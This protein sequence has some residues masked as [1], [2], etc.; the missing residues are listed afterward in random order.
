MGSRMFENLQRE[1]DRL[2]RLQ[3]V[4]V[5][6]EADTEGYVDKECPA[7]GCLFQF[8]ILA[9][10]WTSVVRDEEVFCPSCRHAAPAKSWYTTEQIEAAKQYARGLVINRINGAM[11]ADAAASKR[12]QRP[13]PFLSITLNVKGGRNA[14]LVPIAAA[15][16]LRLRTT[17]DSCGCR[18]S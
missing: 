3:M 9:E 4:E 12:R 14:V 18:Y 11:R 8:K 2:S 17:C 16:P 5:P 6:L 1:L 13:G 10:D 15:E 7:E